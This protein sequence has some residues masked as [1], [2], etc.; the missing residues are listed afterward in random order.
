MTAKEF[1]VAQLADTHLQVTAV[2]EGLA[3]ADWDKKSNPAAM[4]ARETLGHLNE[5]CH[6]FLSEDPHKYAWGS[7]KMGDK[8]NEDLMAEFNQL[9]S[10]CV[11]KLSDSNDDEVVKGAGTY[12]A[13][14][15][16]YHV[17]QLATLRLSLDPEWNAYSIY[18]M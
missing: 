9:R 4:S 17:G 13:L 15:E 5:C 18:G 12:L 16:A 11:D 10:K 14:H 8:P 1:M 6:A 7:Y 3:N 2:Y